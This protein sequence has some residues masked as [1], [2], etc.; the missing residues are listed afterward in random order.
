MKA[1]FTPGPWHAPEPVGQSRQ[2][3]VWG[4]THATVVAD[5]EGP[6]AREREANA[7]LIAA[8]PEL[9]AALLKIFHACD[10]AGDEGGELEMIA[11]LARPAIAKAGGK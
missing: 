1:K 6:N 8:A 5:I 9:L 4:T 11:E 10:G 2:W 7:R 3:T